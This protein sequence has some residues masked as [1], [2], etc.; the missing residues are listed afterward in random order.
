MA[1]PKQTVSPSKGHSRANAKAT[2]L[3]LRSRAGQYAAGKALREKCPRDSHA[4][5]KAPKEGMGPQD[6]Q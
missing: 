3:V 1:S 4:T 2:H 6:E 5:W